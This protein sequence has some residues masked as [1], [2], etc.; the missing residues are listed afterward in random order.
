MCKIFYYS[1]YE[2]FIQLQL[3]LFEYKHQHTSRVLAIT[4][5]YYHFKPIYLYKIQVL[6]HSDTVV[7]ACII[8]CWMHF[9]V[10]PCQWVG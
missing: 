6:T 10:L 1:E 7:W 9:T 4:M 2:G 5:F 3:V 8:E